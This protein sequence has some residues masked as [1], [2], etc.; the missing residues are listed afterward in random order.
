MYVAFMCSNYFQF[1]TSTLYSGRLNSWF[2]ILGSC[3]GKI[4]TKYK[5]REILPC[6]YLL[7]LGYFM[8]FRSVFREPCEVS[9]H[10]GGD[11]VKCFSQQKS[12]PGYGSSHLLM[13][14]SQ[15]L[16]TVFA[17]LI[18]CFP[19]WHVLILLCQSLP[20]SERKLGIL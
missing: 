18:V 3:C 5:N 6:L 7:I 11:M 1:S 9:V 17:D 10:S 20:A 16:Y 4:G 2:R 19:S 14:F 15:I 8:V 13:P 12:E